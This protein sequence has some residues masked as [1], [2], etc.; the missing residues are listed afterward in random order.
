MIRIGPIQEQII[1]Y[2]R[3]C[4]NRASFWIGMPDGAAMR[5]AEGSK[6]WCW[7]QVDESLNRL[8]ARGIVSRERNSMVTLLKYKGDQ[9]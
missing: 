4:N 7:E 1:A 8:E 9:S 2:L 6:I 3:T 5:D